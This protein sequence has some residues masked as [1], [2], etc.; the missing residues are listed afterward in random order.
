M[1]W[2]PACCRRAGTERPHER[3]VNAA[4]IRSLPSVL[5]R[6]LKSITEEIG[7]TLL[8]TT[9]S[10]ILNEARDFATGL[11]DAKG[12]MLEQTEYIP[13]LAFALQP[14]CEHVIRFFGDDIAPG[15]VIPAQRRV[16]RRQPEQRC[17]GVSP[18]VPRRAAD[19]LV[20]LQGTP[21]RHR[22][23]RARRLQS[24]RRARSGRR[25]CAFRRSRSI[26][27]G[28]LRHD[29]WRFDL[30]QHSPAHRRGRH[31]GADRRH[32]GGRARPAR[33][34]RNDTAGH[35]SRP[36]RLPVR[37]H[38]AHGAQGNRERSRTASIAARASRS[39]TAS[40]RT[41]R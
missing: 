18:G 7:L 22:R 32:A 8:R 33:A 2:A 12:R 26:E 17:R 30:R 19:R 25:R 31:Q 16:L 35:G 14:S 11:Y 37:Q 40:R 29:V 1:R 34:G 38:R 23:R 3:A 6:R 21:G 28:R 9:R 36:R 20:G 5:Q 24:R 15:D 10:P 41:R 39:T 4:S 27:R 13:V